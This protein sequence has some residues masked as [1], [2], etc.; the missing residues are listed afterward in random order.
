MRQSASGT[1]PTSD[2]LMRRVQSTDDAEAF[3]GLFQRYSGKAHRVAR[4]ICHDD[5]GTDVAVQEAFVSMWTGRR[6][7]RASLG[8]VETW[9][10]SIVRHQAIAV[11]RSDGLRARRTAP[12]VNFER[13][14][15]E[16]EDVADVALYAEHS[17]R[18]RGLLSRLP[19]QQREVIALAF[20]AQLTHREISDR[21]RLPA[22]T[23]K[24]RMR[25]GLDKLRAEI[26]DRGSGD[27]ALPLAPKSQP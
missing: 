3:A 6:T 4:S 5:H 1:I 16:A 26:D 9:L 17:D 11:A 10:M 13:L 20:Y 8:G 21:L 19:V 14:M 15:G 12:V 22:G 7:Y 18:L 23:I 2:H 24:G 27:E 25:L